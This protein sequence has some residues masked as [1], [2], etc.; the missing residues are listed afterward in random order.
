MGT[1]RV[2]ADVV[3]AGGGIAGLEAALAL[4]TLAPDARVHLLSRDPWL[5]TRRQPRAARAVAPPQRRFGPA[6]PG[7][8]EAGLREVSPAA[9]A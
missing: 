8:V 2:D 1:G 6:P 4:R 5:I 3:V 7:T 9:R